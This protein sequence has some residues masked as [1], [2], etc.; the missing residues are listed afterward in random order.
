M[1]QT[2]KADLHIHTTY[3]DGT[4][5]VCDVLERAAASHLPVIAITD[6]DTIDGALKGRRLA[7]QFGVEVIIG[8]EVS[9]REGH[10]LAL[11]IES[12]L[13]PHRPVTETIA[14]VHAQGGLCIAAHPYDWASA[15]LGQTRLRV[16]DRHHH[17]W[18]VW[19]VDAL[20]V[21]NAGLSWPRNKRNQMAQRV[22]QELNIPAVGGSDSH[23]LATVGCGYTFFPGTS[24]DDLYR[25]I[26]G[27]T[28]SWG[29][30]CWSAADQLQLGW[31][32][33]R[34]RSLRGALAWAFADLP[35]FQQS[36]RPV[37]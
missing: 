35:L 10:L 2:G 9:T 27:N 5:S 20:E 18:H 3:S 37:V 26:V 16:A 6:H 22:A 25:A 17:P 13:P 8:E 32:L 24:A 11:F 31:L 33:V 21:F 15:S 1:H 12:E 36:R 7:R 23:S 34:R 14:A 30:T 29:G 19:K 28:V 4:A